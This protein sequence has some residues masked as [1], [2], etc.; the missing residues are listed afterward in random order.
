[1]KTMPLK[2]GKKGDIGYSYI[3]MIVLGIIGI[4]LILYIFR[5]SFGQLGDKLT[6]LLSQAKP[7]T[8]SAPI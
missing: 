2:N 5:G 6:A 4:I 7:Q 1:M 3:I 8:G